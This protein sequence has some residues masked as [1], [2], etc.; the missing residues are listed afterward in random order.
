MAALAIAGVGAD[1]YT[2]HRAVEWQHVAAILGGIG[3]ASLCI[4]AIDGYQVRILRTAGSQIGRVAGVWTVVF[5]L[6]LAAAVAFDRSGLPPVWVIDWY[7][8]GMCL[9]AVG[10][11]AIGILV[12][13]WVAGGRL[14][15]RAVIVGGGQAAADLIQSLAANRNSGIRICGI[16]DDRA[17][18]RSPTMIE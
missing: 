13:N 2:G 15:R 12:R 8:A 14:A 11:V 9:L 5:G 17:D 18:D 10:R 1:I 4:Q 3:L 6:L 7:L 16:F